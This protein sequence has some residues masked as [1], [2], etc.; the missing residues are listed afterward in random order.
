MIEFDTVSMEGSNSLGRSIELVPN[1]N[2]M[3]KPIK[4]KVKKPKV[5][6]VEKVKETPKTYKLVVS[7]NDTVSKT[8]TDDLFNAI[9]SFKPEFIRTAVSIEVTKNGKTNQR[10]VYANRAKILFQNRIALEIFIRD[11][12]L[13]L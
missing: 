7:V 12:T 13:T 9:M 5:E 8:E 11:I 2:K 10:Y 6:K 1:N 3:A 4:E